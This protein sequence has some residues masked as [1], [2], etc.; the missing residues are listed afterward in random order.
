MATSTKK[1]PAK[2]D[3]A[4]PLE[5]KLRIRV[6]AYEH[7]ILEVDVSTW[8]V[9]GDKEPF[10]TSLDSHGRQGWELVSTAQSARWRWS[11][12]STSPQRPWMALANPSP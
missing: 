9:V 4:Q 3:A 6:R 2:K 8:T 5:P 12:P 1:A 7:K 10:Q 11:E